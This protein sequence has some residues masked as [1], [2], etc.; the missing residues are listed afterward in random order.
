ML[1]HHTCEEQLTGGTMDNTYNE[2]SGTDLDLD[3]DMDFDDDDS[4]DLLPILGLSAAVAA[5]VGAILVLAG[6]RRRPHSPGT[7][8][9]HA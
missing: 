6:R 5:V 7:Y 1:A 4:N 3:A 2:F 8:P 9:G